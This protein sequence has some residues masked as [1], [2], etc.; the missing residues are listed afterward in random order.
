DAAI[1]RRALDFFSGLY[2]VLGE[3]D[4]QIRF[5]ALDLVP[6]FPRRPQQIEIPA[7]DL[8]PANR[9]L[10]DRP[11]R[12]QRH[13]DARVGRED[14]LRLFRPELNDDSLRVFDPPNDL[15]APQVRWQQSGQPQP[16]AGEGDRLVIARQV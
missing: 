9:G 2:D 6:G 13:R 12:T 5:A 3:L 7:L 4:L 16:L 15:G 11:G 10:E 8:R 1:G 14:P